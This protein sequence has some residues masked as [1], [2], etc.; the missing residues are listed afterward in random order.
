MKTLYLINFFLLFTLLYGCRTLDDKDLSPQ[1]EIDEM[2]LLVVSE[3]FVFQT[4]Q[5][6]SLTI[7]ATNAAK[8]SLARVPLYIY[9]TNPEEGGKLISQGITNDQGSFTQSLTL[10]SFVEELYI[11]TPYIGISAEHYLPIRGTS[12]ITYTLTENIQDKSNKWI[13]ADKAGSYNFLGNFNTQGVPAYLEA[14]GDVLDVSFLENVNATLP[15]KNPVPT[16]NPQYLANN[17]ETDIRLTEDADVWVTF[18]HEGAGW[19][20]TLGYY[21]YDVNNPPQDVDDI[22]DLYIIFPNVSAAGSGGGLQAG[23]KVHLGRFSGDTAIGWVLI[24]QGWNGSDVGDGIYK[25]YSNP[26]LNPEPNVEDQQH[27]VLIKDAARQR[28]LLGFEDIRRDSPGCDQDFNDAIFYITAN[29]YS[30]ISSESMPEI[31]ETNPDTDGDGANDL[32]DLYPNDADKAFDNYFP[33]QNDTGTLAY[34]DLWPGKGDYDFN[35][36]VVSYHFNLITNANNKITEVVATFVLK[37]IGA[38]YQNGFAFEMPVA[39]S[40]V[41]GVTGTQLTENYIQ[42][43]SNNI[44]A[45]QSKAVV[46]VFDNALAHMQRTSGDFINTEM[47][48][49]KSSDSAPFTLTIQFTEPLEW[50][51]LEGV[52]FNPFII[53]NQQRGYEVHL[54]GQTPTDLAD[55]QLLGTVHD[56][57]NAA[58]DIYYQTQNYLPFA[59]HIPTQFQYPVEKQGIS[60]AYLKF[61]SWAQ[62]NGTLFTDWYLDG[63]NYRNNLNIYNK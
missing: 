19:R 61:T 14:E 45:G 6:I 59:L 31:V 62:S 1:E 13:S 28:I 63:D 51:D 39:A 17:N 56:Y 37:A 2:D 7:Q 26:A 35:D 42:L 27:N 9:E 32:I 16:Y 44:E 29:P 34:E 33:G 43:A 23:D 47:E 10:P 21:T 40:K 20:N 25:V 50:S 15:E 5:N 55:T 3:D 12:Q 52:P 58:S 11:Y 22:E 46:V 48:A 24:A 30:A 18:V 8:Q 4:T 36:L 60:N 54:K 49:G 53:V 41:A 38:S 57:S